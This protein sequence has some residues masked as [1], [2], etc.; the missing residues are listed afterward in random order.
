MSTEQCNGCKELKPHGKVST[1]TF[2]GDDSAPPTLRVVHLCVS[3][4]DKVLDAIDH[5][6]TAKEV[7][8]YE[9]L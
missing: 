3:C 2:H 1:Y 9:R 8:K 6:T 4:R 7:N 5:L